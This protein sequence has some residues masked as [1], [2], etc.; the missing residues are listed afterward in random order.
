MP[1][2][3]SNYFDD[4]YGNRTDVLTYETDD[5]W[6]GFGSVDYTRTVVVTIQGCVETIMLDADFKKHRFG[7]PIA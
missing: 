6:F 3:P 5:D 4:R 2:I 7:T 1:S